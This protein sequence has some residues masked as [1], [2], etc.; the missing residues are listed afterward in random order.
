MKSRQSEET[1]RMVFLNS[2]RAICTLSSVRPMKDSYN[3]S[4]I[5]ELNHKMKHLE[6][7][8]VESHTP[9]KTI[10][11]TDVLTIHLTDVLTIQLTCS[12]HTAD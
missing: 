2:T 1:A 12:D 4:C 6:C 10:H 9:T 7:S 8:S 3:A 5:M 11:L